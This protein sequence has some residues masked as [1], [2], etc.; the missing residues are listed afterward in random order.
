MNH[1]RSQ[2]GKV[3]KAGEPLSFSTRGLEWD[4]DQD[5]YLILIFKLQGMGCDKPC[6]P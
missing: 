5:F 6:D 4:W 1:C 3:P 2:P